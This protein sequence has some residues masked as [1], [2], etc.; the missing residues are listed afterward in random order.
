MKTTTNS[1]VRKASL[2]NGIMKIT[3]IFDTDYNITPSDW[4]ER[5]RFL[6]THFNIDD[7]SYT[8]Q[9]NRH[10]IFN[11]QNGAEV[12]FFKSDAEDVENAFSTTGEQNK[13][14]SVYGIVL[15]ALLPMLS[16]FDAIYFQALR[17]QSNDEKDWKQKQKIYSSL[18][19]R[20]KNNEYQLYVKNDTS[21][22]TQWLLS[23]IPPQ[24]SDFITEEQIALNNAKTIMS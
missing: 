2:N 13:P 19:T 18:A 1:R 9:I 12:S 5:G 17:R 20:I 14:I 11:I 21:T 8:I 4:Q 6:L 10:P 22:E 16:Q 24:N 23:K 7:Q 15:N 3:E